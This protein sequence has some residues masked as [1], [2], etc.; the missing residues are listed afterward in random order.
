MLVTICAKCLTSTTDPKQP[1][2]YCGYEVFE[3]VEATP[4]KSALTAMVVCKG[5][6]ALFD[7]AFYAND[8]PECGKTYIPDA[9]E[10]IEMTPEREAAVRHGNAAR[11]AFMAQERASAAA[12]LHT[13][14]EYRPLPRWRQRLNTLT[15][16]MTQWMKDRIRSR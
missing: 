14:K 10:L 8:C 12:L 15:R 6:T 5:C 13:T 11:D 2:R 1:C 16:G 9:R 7:R 4:S 3:H